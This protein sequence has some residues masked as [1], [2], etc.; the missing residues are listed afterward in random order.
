MSLYSLLGN[1][2]FSPDSRGSLFQI[3]RSWVQSVRLLNNSGTSCY[4]RTKTNNQLMSLHT[5]HI[6]TQELLDYMKVYSIHCLQHLILTFQGGG[7][8]LVGRNT[9]FFFNS[10]TS[11]ERK[12]Q[13]F[14]TIKGVHMHQ[15]QFIPSPNQ[16]TAHWTHHPHF[17][18]YGFHEVLTSGPLFNYPTLPKY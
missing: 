11:H 12:R 4:P 18:V 1:R 2:P 6:R 8:W 14:A 16:H 5:E 10:Y 17:L 3:Q 15:Q 9:L 13:P 7:A